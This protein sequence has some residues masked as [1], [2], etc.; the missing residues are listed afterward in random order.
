MTDLA[1]QK[2]ILISISDSLLEEVDLLAQN[3]NINRSE[4]IREAMKLYIKE[5]KKQHRKEAMKKGYEQMG[6]INL[7][8]ADMCF[9]ADC[10]QQKNYEEKLSECE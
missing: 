9:E 10:Q 8:F 1:H 3:E 7:E 5:R 2:K 6:K 4:F